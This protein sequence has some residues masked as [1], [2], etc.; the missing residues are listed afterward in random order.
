MGRC[1]HGPHATHL[2]ERHL[3]RIELAP[4]LGRQHGVRAQPKPPPDPRGAEAAVEAEGAVAAR[5]HLR[6]ERR[7]QVAGRLRRDRDRLGG[8]ARVPAMVCQ[9]VRAPADGQPRLE[10]AGRASA[11]RRAQ[12]LLELA[13]ELLP[14][15]RA[16]EVDDAADVL[17]GVRHPRGVVPGAVE[18]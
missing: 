15:R 11:R 4:V 10:P 8:R 17:L 13:H 18:T 3:G 12:R 2:R 7:P 5:E 14:R 6:D 9:H 16:R 1:G